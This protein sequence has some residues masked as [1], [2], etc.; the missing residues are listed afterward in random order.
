VAVFKRENFRVSRILLFLVQCLKT[1]VDGCN[2]ALKYNL[3]IFCMEVQYL[4]R[5]DFFK[6]LK[7]KMVT[8]FL[9][10]SKED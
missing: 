6:E 10:K 5:Q 2:S 3:I 1:G 7:I 9:K 4:L 8:V